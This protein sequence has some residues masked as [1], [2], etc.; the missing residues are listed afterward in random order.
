MPTNIKDI[1]LHELHAWVAKLDQPDYRAIQLAKWLYQKLAAD[2]NQMSDL[3]L[4]FRQKLKEQFVITW[5]QVLQKQVSKDGAVKY[6]WKLADG[7]TVESVL[8][9]SQNRFTICVST[10][11]GC[12]LGC[13]FCASGVAGFRRHLNCG[14][15]LDQILAA[16]KDQ[17]NRRI[18]HLVFM[19]M[20]EPMDNYNNVLAAVRW[21]NSSAGLNI[22]A[23]KITISTSGII[24]GIQKLAKEGIQ[25]ELS[26]SLHA[27]NSEVRNRLMPINRKYPIEQ[28]ISACRDYIQRTN[29][30]IT[31][32]YTLISGVNDRVEDAN[33]LAKLLKR[34]KCQ[35]NLIPLN[36][37]REFPHEPPTVE[38]AK[39]FRKRLQSLGVDAT[40]RKT[41]GRDIDGACGQLRLTASSP[42]SLLYARL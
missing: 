26:V 18:T 3:P 22:G 39:Q 12:K 2:F 30:Q 7:E 11:V 19:G 33:D 15:I 24:P 16:R 21:M 37:I 25:V 35:V 9:P 27:G 29:R 23:R 42:Y 20:G 32:E 28:L 14:E 31:F 17:P 1:S 41:M 6:L 10:Q 5:H 36:P 38:V 8:I 13:K 34:M 40:I 4:E